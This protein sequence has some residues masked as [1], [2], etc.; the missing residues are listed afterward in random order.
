MK[1]I[2]TSASTQIKQCTRGKLKFD[3]LLILTL[4]SYKEKIR[5]LLIDTV[6]LEKVNATTIGV[7]IRRLTKIGVYFYQVSGFVCDGARYMIKCYQN[8]IKFIYL[9]DVYITCSAHAIYLV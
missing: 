1:T 3:I 6:A 7:I 9:N 2:I 4:K 5:A 8:I